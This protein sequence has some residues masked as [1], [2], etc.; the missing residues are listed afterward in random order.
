MGIC[1]AVGLA[2]AEKHL[3]AP[4]Q[5]A[6]LRPIVDHYTYAIMGDGC[7]MEGMSGEG[8][9]L[10]AHWEPRQAHRVLRRQPHLHRR[11]HRHLLHR[12][13]LQARY[14]AYGWHVQHVED[15][16]TDLDAI[17]KAIDAAKKLTPA[18]PS[19]R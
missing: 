16:N 1:N 6:R 14:E 19:S 5:Q 9:S 7:N 10:A 17:R 12:G 11:P 18:R 3:A 2:A 4:L 15:G 8:A 13:R